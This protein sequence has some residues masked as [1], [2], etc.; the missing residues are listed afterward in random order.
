LNA[1]S[2]KISIGLARVRKEIPPPG[3]IFVSKKHEARK[4]AKE[5]LRR[6]LKES[7][8]SQSP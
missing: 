3:K 5:Q 4:L 6:E 7:L 8:P 2:K 1:P